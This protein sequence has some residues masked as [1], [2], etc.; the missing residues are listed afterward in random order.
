M[1]RNHKEKLKACCLSALD[2]AIAQAEHAM[3]E[4]QESAN[5]EEKSS[6]GDKYE[7]GRSMSHMERDMHA[8]QLLQFQQERSKLDR[9]DSTV[10]MQKVAKGALVETKEKMYWIAVALGQVTC[11][12]NKVMVVSP[13]SPVAQSMMGKQAGDTFLLKAQQVVIEKV[14]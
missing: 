8:K 3:K 11:G 4:A 5:R 12:Q 13:E 2:E 7:T 6:M 14:S 10:L 1:D 9:I